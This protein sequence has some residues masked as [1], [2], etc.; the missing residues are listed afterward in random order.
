MNRKVLYALLVAI[1]LVIGCTVGFG[2]R[3]AQEE[4]T[5]LTFANLI[6]SIADTWDTDASIKRLEQEAYAAWVDTIDSEISGLNRLLDDL[7][8]DALFEAREDFED[9]IA[10]AEL[11]KTSA[12]TAA[13]LTKE[14]RRQ[15][16][17]M[18]DRLRKVAT[19][20]HRFSE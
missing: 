19:D 3:K 5:L 7:P 15:S 11:S 13:E 14:Y 6:E 1:G 18:A 2:A 16:N 12:N 17:R 9:A 20:L 10:Y 8:A 4:R